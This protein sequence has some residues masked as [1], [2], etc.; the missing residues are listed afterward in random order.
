MV[1]RI[2]RLQSSHLKGLVE[3]GLDDHLE[4]RLSNL[5]SLRNSNMAVHAEG[6]K[7]L[8]AVSHSLTKLSCGYPLRAA[9]CVPRRRFRRHA[10]SA[11]GA[12]P[13]WHFKDAELVSMVELTSRIIHLD[14]GGGK[15][16]WGK[17]KPT[18]GG[19]PSDSSTLFLSAG[20]LQ[21]LLRITPRLAHLRFH[22]LGREAHGIMCYSACPA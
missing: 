7:H 8:G 21:T 22:V 10:A 12:H 11:A 14:I 13:A 4:E 17:G 3:V 20:V 1:P 9:L 2:A 15:G 18:P 5:R 19:P 6:L 16:E